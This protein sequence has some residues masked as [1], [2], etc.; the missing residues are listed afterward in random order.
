MADEAPKLIQIGKGGP[1]VQKHGFNLISE[2]EV[3]V[4][5]EARVLEIRL[6]A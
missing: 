1:G 3:K 4:D 2:T 6:L 5:V